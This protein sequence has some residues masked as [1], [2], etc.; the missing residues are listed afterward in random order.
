MSVREQPTRRQQPSG[1][2][3]EIPGDFGKPLV[4]HTFDVLS[5][6][7]YNRERY[8]R[9]GPVYWTK[10]FGR[11]A[12]NFVG[13]DAV[14]EVLQN[15]DHAFANGPGWGFLIGKFFPRGLMLLDFDE[16]HRHRRIMQQA[17]TNERLAGY[18]GPMNQ[19]LAAGIAG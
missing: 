10:A 18:L 14:G 6:K 1:P 15:R 17:F 12:V 19:T 13:P 11:K 4:G 16:H 8:D 7:S 2:L 5:G 3:K 9:Y